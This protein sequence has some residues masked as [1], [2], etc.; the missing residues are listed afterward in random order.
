MVEEDNCL[1]EGDILV[2]PSMED[3]LGSLVGMLE[4][5]LLGILLVV[6]GGES[7]MVDCVEMEYPMVGNEEMELQWGLSGN[8]LWPHQLH[9][10]PLPPWERGRCLGY[11][12]RGQKR[13]GMGRR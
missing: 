7:E 9:L 4:D 2:R 11:W 10:Q 6:L 1:E 12:R 13:E 5:S 8:I 3:I